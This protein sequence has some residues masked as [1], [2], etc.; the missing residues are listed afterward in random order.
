MDILL[1][2]W[3]IGIFLMYL[4][5]RIR[6]HRDNIP[7]AVGEYKAVFELASIMHTELDDVEKDEGGDASK[8]SETQLRR[9]ITKDLNG[10]SISY[11]SSLLVDKDSSARKAPNAPSVWNFRRWFAKERWWIGGITLAICG[12]PATLWTRIGV[13]FPLGWLFPV[14]FVFSM[15]VGR[16]DG[17]RG[18][19]LGWQTVFWTIVSVA[20]LM[21]YGMTP[22]NRYR[23]GSDLD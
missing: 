23:S 9:R 16:G 17:S 13:Y 5:A 14:L 1:L 12:V 7:G 18:V 15:Y 22:S 8:L 6:M 20:L 4:R 3:M 21:G 11:R 2:I 19:L 10:G